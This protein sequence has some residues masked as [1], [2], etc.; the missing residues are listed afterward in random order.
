MSKMV[1]QIVGVDQHLRQ[2]DILASTPDPVNGE[3]L[4]S[5]NLDRFR[6]N[7]VILW[8][9][10]QAE[11]PLGKAIAID[12]TPEGLKMKIQFASLQAN[13]KA[14]Q[15][16]NQVVEEI[17][18]AVSVGFEPGEETDEGGDGEVT[19][20]QNEL[21][22]V[23]F[24]SVGKDENAGT[25]ALNPDAAMPREKT[26][27][28][29][30]PVNLWNPNAP[31]GPQNETQKSAVVGR[32]VSPIP[33]TK[34][35]DNTVDEVDEDYEAAGGEDAVAKTLRERKAAYEARLVHGRVSR[36]DAAKRDPE[37][38]D[39]PDSSKVPEGQ[40][41]LIEHGEEQELLVPEGQPRLSERATETRA[42]GSDDCKEL[43]D[44]GDSIR[45]FDETERKRKLRTK[46]RS[47]D[48]LREDLS[49]Q[50]TAIA[51]AEKS[52]AQIDKL[53]STLLKQ[54]KAMTTQLGK[55]RSRSAGE[56]VTRDNQGKFREAHR[57][58]SIALSRTK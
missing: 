30:L 34:E 38:G 47:F 7:P 57:A 44:P 40:T 14:E 43:G 41:T 21:L 16:W 53:K 23:S 27:E 8:A 3:A 11:L 35:P 46:T 36:S 4:L 55:L 49:A 56:T 15:V 26:T 37:D 31:V 39:G 13:P 32:G 25:A 58:K 5:W 48:R 1:G 33:N 22:E 24:V 19:R 45:M 28:D 12:E 51:E 50:Q 9:H 54:S 6:K 18:R 2:V 42:Y 20:R 29:M 17:V 52:K 10:N